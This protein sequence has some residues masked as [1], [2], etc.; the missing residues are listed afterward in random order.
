T[1]RSRECRWRLCSLRRR[2]ASQESVKHTD[3][4]FGLGNINYRS[5]D[6]FKRWR[7]TT[8]FEAVKC[9]RATNDLCRHGRVANSLAADNESK[10]NGHVAVRLDRNSDWIVS[11]WH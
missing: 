2:P 7:E 9:R 1:T 5:C 4:W 3:P 10:R 11:H 8:E 6:E